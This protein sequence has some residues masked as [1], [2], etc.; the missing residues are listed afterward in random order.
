[1]RH[2]AGEVEV[3][4]RRGRSVRA[5][6]PDRRDVRRIEVRSGRLHPCSVVRSRTQP[7]SSMRNQSS[8]SDPLAHAD[9]ARRA[10]VVVVA[11]A[12][13][14]DPADEPDVEVRIAVELLIEARVVVVADVR[15]PE[16]LGRDELGG[17]VQTSRGGRDRC[18]PEPAR[19]AEVARSLTSAGGSVCRT[20]V[21]ASQHRRNRGRHP[22]SNSNPTTGVSLPY[23]S[24]PTPNVWMRELDRP[25]LRASRRRRTCSDRAQS[26][27]RRLGARDARAGTDPPPASIANS[28]RS[29]GQRSRP[30]ASQARYASCIRAG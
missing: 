30:N 10:V 9:R 15:S 1:M 16:M 28:T 17:E 25:P 3:D 21:R 27:R 4:R 11:R 12:L 2:S 18:P 22:V 20:G 6:M 7:S 13:A 23:A 19:A 8:N 5:W 29:V 14:V 26:G 24:C